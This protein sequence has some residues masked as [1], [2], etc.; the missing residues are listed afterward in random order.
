MTKAIEIT[1]RGFHLDA[2]NHVN[3]ARFLE[4]MEDARWAIFEEVLRQTQQVNCAMAIVNININ[5]RQVAKLY[6]RLL[7][8]GTISKIGNRS[9]VM[10]QHVKCAETD[11]LIADADLTCVIVDN[12]TG[13]AIP[14]N[15]EWR[16]LLTGKAADS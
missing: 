6:Q 14:I 1:V 13:K 10:T 5:Y 11:Q 7:V 12:R 8:D 9:V 4:F 2:F 3:N 15:D 16:T